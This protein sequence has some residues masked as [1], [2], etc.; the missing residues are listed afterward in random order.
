MLKPCANSTGIAHGGR[1]YVIGDKNI[2][3]LAQIY[4]PA[5]KYWLLTTQFIPQE[6]NGYTV[7]SVD[8]RMILLTWSGYRGVKLWHWVED[9]S[10]SAGKWQLLQFYAPYKVE[11][12]R[13]YE[14]RV[15]L[16]TIGK[17]VFIM[18]G[19][20][21]HFCWVDGLRAWPVLPPP[22]FRPCDSQG[23]YRSES[24]RAFRI[25]RRGNRLSWRRYPVY[26]VGSRR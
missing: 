25:S 4:Y 1:F 11:R 23:V 12:V 18:V 5:T 17:E 21:R 9:F 7:G 14:N 20:N 16:V 22:F 26:R 2:G 13:I 19:A 15:R 8:G 6:A 24:V 10:M 3:H